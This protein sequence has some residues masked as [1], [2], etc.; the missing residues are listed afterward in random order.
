M[1]IT[2]TGPRSIGKTTI[3]KMLAKEMKIKYI[4]SDEIGEK[5]TRKIGG[6]D[7]AIKSGAIRQ[8]IKTKGYTLLENI[9][10]KEKNYVFDLS[11]GSFVYTKFPEATFKLRKIAKEKSIVIGLLPSRCKIYSIFL[12]YNRELKREH[13]KNESFIRKVILFWKTFKRYFRFPRVFKKYANFIIYTRGKSAKE[14]VREI[15][16]RLE[17]LKSLKSF[18]N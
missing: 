3:G 15:R 8:I 5:V 18:V 7:K 6:L 17:K 14:A 16:L 11:G 12:L 1:N 13:F 9:Y 10:K 4:S 2:I